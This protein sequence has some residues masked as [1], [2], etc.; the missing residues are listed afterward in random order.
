MILVG[1]LHTSGHHAPEETWAG[2]EFCLNVPK[3]SPIVKGKA[4][5]HGL[6]SRIGW[7]GIKTTLT[8]CGVNN[9]SPR[10]L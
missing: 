10:D 4:A 6:E 1:V 2:F 5:K 3:Q 7:I 8:L 9:Y